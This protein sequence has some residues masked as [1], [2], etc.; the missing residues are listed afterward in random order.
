MEEPIVALSQAGAVVSKSVEVWSYLS[1]C[2]HGT[3]L[4]VCL[5]ACPV[6]EKDSG[7][8]RTVTTAAGGKTNRECDG[9]H[10]PR[11]EGASRVR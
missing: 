6:G 11:A 2:C 8:G 5:S 4:F 7:V 1:L 3:G 9:R 10:C